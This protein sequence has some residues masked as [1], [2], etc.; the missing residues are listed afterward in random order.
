MRAFSV[1]FRSIRDFYEEMF[2]LVSLSIVWWVP[3]IAI[4][5]LVLPLARSLPSWLV[6]AAVAVLAV[7]LA[8]LTTGLCQIGYRIAYELR[9]DS[10]FFK[11]SVRE[12]FW[13][14][15]KLGL[16]NVV[17]LV[18][19]IVNLLFY[20]RFPGTLRLITI[21]WIY[22]LIMW[23]AAQLYLF[24]LL[25]EQQEPRVLMAVRNAAVLVLTRPLFT[26]IVLLL[27]FILT[28]LCTVLPVLLI[29]IWPGLM[30]LIS[31]RALAVILEEARAMAPQDQ[32]RDDGD[33]ND[34]GE[35]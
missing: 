7:L 5:V 9:V 32:H 19:I 10:S 3:V 23:G 1:V 31:T 25:I 22:V 15:V 35:E 27:A 13:P 24:P 20:A 33:G 4:T 14:S 34:E 21:L 11:E 29:L 18:T 30:A 2:L 8:P 6:G 28:A 12:F 17:I 16:L 26:L